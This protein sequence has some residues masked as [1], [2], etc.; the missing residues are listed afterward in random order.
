MCC[1]DE[2]RRWQ[3]EEG[4]RSGN[5]QGPVVLGRG[6]HTCRGAEAALFFACSS[7]KP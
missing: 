4:K 5:F 2:A 1:S 3:R 6:D 7:P